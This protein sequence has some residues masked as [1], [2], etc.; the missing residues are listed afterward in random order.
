MAIWNKFKKLH[1]RHECS[2]I[3][4]QWIVGLRNFTVK[5]FDSFS[6][7]DLMSMAATRN[8]K[9]QRYKEQKEIEKKLHDLRDIVEQDHVDDEVKVILAFVI[10]R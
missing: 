2:R 4:N 3:A 6:M 10:R 5:L 8:S 9:I 7:Q 1:D